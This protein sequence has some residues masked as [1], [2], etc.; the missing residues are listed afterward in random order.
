MV[1]KV[2]KVVDFDYESDSSS[3]TDS[4]S[5][6][7]SPTLTPKKKMK[8]S[9]DEDFDYADNLVANLNQSISGTLNSEDEYDELEM[10]EEEDVKPIKK[11]VSSSSNTS[12]SLGKSA[13]RPHECITCKKA[14]ARKS[15]LVRH[16]RI[17]TNE[18]RV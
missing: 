2:V 9:S 11:V 8:K 3:L 16:A 7:P 13:E 15:D 18:R 1:R 17:H 14:F 12:S 10:D 4:E 5:S 6:L